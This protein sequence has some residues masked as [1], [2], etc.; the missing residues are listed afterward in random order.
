MALCACVCVHVQ[1]APIPVV[2]P[3]PVGSKFAPDGSDVWDGDQEAVDREEEAYA[4]GNGYHWAT[5]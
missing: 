1:G 5:V 4:T 2:P 3:L